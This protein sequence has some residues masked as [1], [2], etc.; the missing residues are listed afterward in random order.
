MHA[1]QSASSAGKAGGAAGED[2]SDSCASE[3]DADTVCQRAPGTRNPRRPTELPSG[4][5]R[6]GRPPAGRHTTRAKRSS[7]FLVMQSTSSCASARRPRLTRQIR[8]GVSCGGGR[9]HEPLGGGANTHRCRET[10]KLKEF[11]RQ[12][13]LPGP[14]RFVL[15][16][17][18]S[19]RG[20][21]SQDEGRTAITRTSWHP[22]GLKAGFQ[23]LTSG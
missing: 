9:V 17:P 23:L 8:T 1:G 21:G 15:P 10:R 18:S 12:P 14:G 22:P 3:R 6:E 5:E 16:A 4:P 13:G 19:I 7:G 20:T 11:R 2:C